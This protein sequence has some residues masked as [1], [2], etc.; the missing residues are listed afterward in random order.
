VENDPAFLKE[1]AASAPI[2]IS[3]AEGEKKVQDIRIGRF[4]DDVAGPIPDAGRARDSTST[5][6]TPAAWSRAPQ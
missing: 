6:A 4:A 5:P 1:L 3:V 2:K